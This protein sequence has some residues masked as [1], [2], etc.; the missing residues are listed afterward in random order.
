MDI[1]L[2]RLLKQHRQLDDK[3]KRMLEINPTPPR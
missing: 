3:A 2:E 1:H